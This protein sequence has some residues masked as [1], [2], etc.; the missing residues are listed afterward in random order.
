M[1]YKKRWKTVR[2]LDCDAFIAAK[3]GNV[4]Y[5]SCTEI[6]DKVLACVIIPKDREPI[7]IT[8]V[9][10]ENRA[11]N[12]VI[13][14]VR[15][16]GN[17]PYVPAYE[18]NY[19]KAIKK[20]LKEIKA[21]NVIADSR[22]GIHARVKDIVK[23]MRVHKDKEEVRLLRKAA[24]F[25]RNAS[26]KLD[27]IVRPGKTETEIAEE[28]GH[29]LRKHG[30]ESFPAIVA[31]GKNSAY[32]HHNPTEKK[33][34]RGE[35]VI[36][37]FGVCYKGYCSDVTRTVLTGKNEKLEKIFGIVQEAQNEAIKAIRIGERIGK[38]DSMIRKTFERNGLGKYFL[39]FSGHG[40]G[41]EIHEAPSLLP[42]AREKIEKK[43]V[44]TVE[45]GLYIPKMGG[46]RIEDDILVGNRTEILTR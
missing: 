8:S 4:K 2:E 11:R 18:K 23:D 31:S 38:L 33:I 17:L 36:C 46:V 7:G 45:P 26:K 28:F 6:P 27:E 42:N 32:P 16:V 35:A 39:H 13:R 22:I 1:N 25:T 12:T 9:L 34:K 24:A 30:P 44:F 37:D 5:L 29:I 3:P 43:M 10:N 21:K 19:R 40:L 14:D 20:I 15:A 41:L